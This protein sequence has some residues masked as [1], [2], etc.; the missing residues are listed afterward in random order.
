MQNLNERAKHILNLVIESYIQTGSPVGSKTLSEHMGMNL[1]SASIR[2]VMADL[3][4]MG[5]LYSPHTSAGRMPTEAALTVFVEGLIEVN[6]LSNKERE[7]IRA[8]LEP[9]LKKPVSDKLDHTS[10]LISGL[11]DCAGLVIAP[12][13][14]AP[15][16]EIEF[17]KLSE[18]RILTVMVHE[19]G[20]VENRVIELKDDVP[21]SNLTK[22]ANYL[23]S[24][25]TGQNIETM[26]KDL[27]QRIENDKKTLDDITQNLVDAGIA[28]L[29]PKN[30]GQHL[31]VRG[32]ANLL[33]SV[34]AMEDLEKLRRLFVALED[35]DTLLKMLNA[36]EGAD[37]VQIFIGSNNTL[38][39]HSGCSLIISPYKDSQKNVIGAVGVIGPT[40]LNYRRVIPVINY[41]SEILSEII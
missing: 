16:R 9:H 18:K 29:T 19:N 8:N 1:S 11:S 33:E 14:E 35:K 38:F 12:K 36:V 34:T 13:A 26:R 7:N 2:N 6:N 23:N 17:I 40:R 15:L 25:L 24:Y 31:I 21:R 5:Y 37:G 28:E 30:L 22:A 3:E 32:Q 4:N 27:L 10:R 39:E 20:H 41:T